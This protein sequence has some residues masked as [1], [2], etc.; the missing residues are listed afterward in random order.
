MI[1]A[2]MAFPGTGLWVKQIF[3][4]RCKHDTAVAV[5]P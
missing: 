4:G 1:A 2:I 3:A 5:E